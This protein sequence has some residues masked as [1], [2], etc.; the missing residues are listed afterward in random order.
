M[1]EAPSPDGDGASCGSGDAGRRGAA[2]RG[3]SAPERARP[4]RAT[5]P[6]GPQGP[7]YPMAPE[8]TLSRS[9][10]LAATYTATV[11]GATTKNGTATTPVA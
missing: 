1:S 9:T 5:G 11:S 10:Q 2:R 7:P 8:R 3:A 6:Q 4:R